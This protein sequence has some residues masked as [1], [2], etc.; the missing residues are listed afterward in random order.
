MLTAFTP[1]PATAQGS[2]GAFQAYANGT[3]QHVR[4]VDAGGQTLANVDTSFSGATANSSGLGTAVNNIFNEPVQPAQ[5]S[6]NSYSRA[7]AAEVGLGAKFPANVDPSQIILPKLTESAAAPSQAG[8]RTDLVGPVNADPL[9]YLAAATNK[10]QSVWNPD[11]CPIG[12]PISYGENDLADAQLLNASSTKFP[13]GQPVISETP[14]GDST[15]TNYN[16]SYTYLYPVGPSTFGVGAVNRQ[17]LAPVTIGKGLAPGG[18]DLA[19]LTLL[20]TWQLRVEDSG[21]G[22]PT[23]TYAAFDNL[24]NQLKGAT[25]VATLSIAGM[26]VLS[27]TAQQVFG[28]TGLDVD[29]PPGPGPYLAQVHIG[30]PPAPIAGKTHGYTTDAVLVNALNVPGQVDVADVRYGHMEAQAVAPAGGVSCTI[31][32]SKVFTDAN[33]TVTNSLQ[34]GNNFLWKITFP[35]V[36]I[37]KELACDL[38]NVTVTDTATAT[39]NASATINQA[40]HNG[41]ITAATVDSSHNGG[42]TWSLGTFHPN[43]PPIVLTINGT[44]GK[45]AGTITNT[46]NITA[47]L[48]NCTGGALG[49]AFVTNGSI[50]GKAATI[51][52][53]AFNGNATT[54]AVQV[55]AAAVLPARLAETGQKDPWL[56]VLGGG[57]LLGALALMRSRRHLQEVKSEQY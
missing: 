53:T 51:Q 43:D 26:P 47:T 14:S 38:T 41:K 2:F 50:G 31:P 28:A 48:G 34:G 32:A 5:A 22:A 18:A 11:F 9:L 10:A 13:N 25:P 20:G 21:S 27:L 30:T 49:K 52:G 15:T 12:Q 8:V 56:P 33:G 54:G 55:S 36:D 45:G 42:I 35:T 4:V 29:I 19:V 3:K 39:G 1:G 40:D 37:S 57:L 24:G 7:A 46:A 6:K 16:Q 17:V 23:V 44:L